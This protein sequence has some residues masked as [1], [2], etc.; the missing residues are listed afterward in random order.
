MCVDLF[1]NKVIATDLDGTLLYPKDKK[2]IVCK[3]NLYFLQSFIDKGGKVIIVS[4]RSLAYGLRVK[5]KIN[6]NI[7]IISFNGGA[8]YQDNKIIYSEAIP[9][10]EI[11]DMSEDLFKNFKII[12]LAL[13]SDDGIYIK[14]VFGK[15]MTKFVLKAYSFLQKELAEKMIYSPKL[16]EETLKSKPI[17]KVLCIFGFGSRNI[18]RAKEANKIIRNAYEDIECSWSNGSLEIT[19]KNV[20]KGEAI[21]KYCQINNVPKEDVFV[22][23]DSGNDISMFKAFSENSF[24]MAHSQ[25]S[26]KK[27]AKYTVETIADLSRYI[28]KNK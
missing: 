11:I 1:M 16:F 7:S 27:Y 5:E 18:N 4:G 9:N 8:L 21:L 12:A 17:Y 23:G 19:A 22:I 14:S 10:K 25:E 28:Y 24:C 3:P 26:V 2:N 20:N 13:F 15:G 6:R